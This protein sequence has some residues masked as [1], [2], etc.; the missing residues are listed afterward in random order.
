MDFYGTE[1]PPNIVGTSRYEFSEWV[2]YYAATGTITFTNGTVQKVSG[3]VVGMCSG[4]EVWSGT[5]KD[6]NGNPHDTP[7]QSKYYIALSLRRQA[8][9]TSA[10]PQFHLAILPIQRAYDSGDVGSNTLL[11]IDDSTGALLSQQDLPLS[12]DPH[13]NMSCIYEISKLVN[14][15][16][17]LKVQVISQLALTNPNSSANPVA[18]G[19]VCGIGFLDNAS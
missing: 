2:Q 3:Q 8:P 7:A 1:G 4:M 6:P 12:S 15:G 14:A 5:M 9:S 18:G 16:D 17:F 10:G 19:A 13:N 11:V